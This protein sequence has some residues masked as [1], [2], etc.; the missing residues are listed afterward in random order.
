MPALPSF[1]SWLADV[2]HVLDVETEGRLRVAE[3]REDAKRFYLRRFNASKAARGLI[4]IYL[5]EA[6]VFGAGEL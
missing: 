5:D 3:F 2:E 4:A 1:A 6:G